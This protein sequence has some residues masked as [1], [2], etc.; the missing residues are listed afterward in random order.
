MQRRA[1]IYAKRLGYFYVSRN[2][3]GKRED[4]N[5]STINVRENEDRQYDFEQ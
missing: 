3:Q 5:L 2:V 4:G 1:F